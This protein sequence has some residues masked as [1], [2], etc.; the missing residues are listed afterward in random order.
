MR[1]IVASSQVDLTYH[2]FCQLLLTELYHLLCYSKQLWPF[3]YVVDQQRHLEQQ[4]PDFT[5]QWMAAWQLQN[6]TEQGQIMCQLARQT[7]AKVQCINEAAAGIRH[8]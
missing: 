6:V 7:L 1:K 5:A 2:Y 4:F 3:D 8:R